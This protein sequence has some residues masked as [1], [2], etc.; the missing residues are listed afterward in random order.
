MWFSGT[1]QNEL[2]EIIERRALTPYFQTIA[3]APAVKQDAF[4]RIL[5]A[6]ALTADQAVAVGDSQTEYAAAKELG[7]T[8]CWYRGV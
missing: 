3:G 7:H 2:C 1:P 4:R 5:E 8:V 6:S